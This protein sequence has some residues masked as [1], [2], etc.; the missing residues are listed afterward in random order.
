[1][2]NKRLLNNTP[3]NW[4]TIDHI[5]ML[6]LMRE[7][8]PSHQEVAVSHDRT[9]NFRPRVKHCTTEPPNTLM[10]NEPTTQNRS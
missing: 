6:G 7:R 10:D 4:V 2:D 3:L 9:H 8:C 1:M 5:V